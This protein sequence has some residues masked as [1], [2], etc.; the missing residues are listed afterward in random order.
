M[1]NKKNKSSVFLLR[2]ISQIVIQIND[3]FKTLGWNYQITDNDLEFNSDTEKGDVVFPCFFLAKKLKISP[4][5][6]AKKLEESIQSKNL[7]LSIRNING[8]LNFYLDKQE[9]SSFV[10]EQILKEKSRYGAINIG[11]KK[12]VMIEFSSPNTNKPL[13]LG[14]LRNIVLGWSVSKILEFLNFKV[15]KASLLNDRGIHI[16]KSM[17]A[18][19][20]WGN[21]KKP[22]IKS[23]H[24]VGDYYVLFE[25]KNKSGDELDKELSNLLIK[26]EKKDPSTI[27]L[28]KKMNKWAEDGFKETY[29]KLKVDFDKVY[30]ESKIYEKGKEIVLKKYQEGIFDKNKDGAIFANLENFNLPNK[31]VLRSDSTAIYITQDI[32]LTLLKFKEYNLEKS[33]YCVGKEQELYLKQLF[34]ILD[35]LNYSYAD[36]CFHLSHGMVFL[37]EGKMKS[38]EG[39]VVDADNLIF[40][41]E[42]FALKE[43]LKR[44]SNFSEKTLKEVSENISISALKYYLLRSAPTK[45]IYFN[46]KKSLSFIGETGPYIQYSYVRIC[47]ILKKSKGTNLKGFN[48]SSLSLGNK[49]ESDLIMSL[50][51]FPLIIKKAGLSYNPSILAHYLYKLADKSNSYYEKFPILKEDKNVRE[52]RL[53]LIECIKIVLENGLGLLGIPVIKKM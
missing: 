50:A 14:H 26:L 49:E 27:S 2:V 13:H 52:S 8:Y 37:P 38:R 5:D 47:S 46:P 20:K 16:C 41:L 43:I 6:I 51:E 36:K 39:K 21:D 48:H 53:I 18:Y 24:F 12:K 31:V 35:L 25:K 23:D 17:L 45:D 33:I 19:K 28:W 40:E 30:K 11:R 1:N 4:N 10:L 44:D 9:V 22:D 42:S 15:I 3:A 32:Y 7:V 29:S 34:K